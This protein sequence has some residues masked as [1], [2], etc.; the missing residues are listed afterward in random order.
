MET[1]LIS[2]GIRHYEASTTWMLGKRLNKYRACGSQSVRRR[3]DIGDFKR[4]QCTAIAVWHA[5]IRDGERNSIDVVRG[6][7]FPQPR[8][9][10][11]DRVF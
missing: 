2:I 10:T 1:N 9:S 7:E 6:Q 3:F 4:R 11:I 5:N 8:Y